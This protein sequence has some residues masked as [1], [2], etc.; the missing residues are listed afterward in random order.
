MA[1][2][3]CRFNLKGWLSV[4]SLVMIQSTREIKGKVSFGRRYFIRSSN[5][6]ASR[7][8][9]IIRQ[10]WCVENGLQGSLDI[11]LRRRAGPY[12]RQGNSAENFSMLRHIAFNLILQDKTTEAGV[13]NRR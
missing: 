2:R 4:R 11:A 10:H 6:G 9:K 13:K 3:R 7:M 5:A 8:R 1:G 12:M